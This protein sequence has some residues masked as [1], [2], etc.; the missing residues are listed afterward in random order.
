MILIVT[1]IVYYYFKSIPFK[2]FIF[3]NLPLKSSFLDMYLQIIY[4]LQISPSHPLSYRYERSLSPELSICIGTAHLLG[5]W[6]RGLKSKAEFNLPGKKEIWLLGYGR[7]NEREREKFTKL[8]RRVIGLG[9]VEIN[10]VYL[11]C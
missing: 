3:Y 10:R 11:V 5:M 8:K 2:S 1:V 7:A 9:L 6:L 4:T